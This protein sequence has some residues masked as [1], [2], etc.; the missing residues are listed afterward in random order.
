MT[1]RRG[2]TQFFYPSGGDILFIVSMDCSF[3]DFCVMAA[4]TVDQ[5]EICDDSCF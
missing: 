1:V 3:F 5:A 4:A 2:G